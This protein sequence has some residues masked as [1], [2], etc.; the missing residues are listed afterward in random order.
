MIEALTREQLDDMQCG[1]PGCKHE[2]EFGDPLFLHSRC[3]PKAGTRVHYQHG[4]L[5]IECR[6]CER[7]VATIAVAHRP[8]IFA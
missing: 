6:Q 7:H 5:V 8:V 4:E 3:H 1:T 2:H